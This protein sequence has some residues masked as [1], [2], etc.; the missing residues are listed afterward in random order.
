MKT[1][2]YSQLYN[3]IQSTKKSNVKNPNFIKY[4]EK[5]IKSAYGNNKITDYEKSRLLSF[6]YA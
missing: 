6:L 2:L 1:K 3:S 4:I 5:Q